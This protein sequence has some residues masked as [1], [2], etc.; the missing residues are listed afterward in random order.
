MPKWAEG[1]QLAV[2]NGTLVDSTVLTDSSNATYHEVIKSDEIHNAEICAIWNLG[3]SPPTVATVSTYIEFNEPVTRVL[4]YSSDGS[5]WT[6]ISMGM[7]PSP[8]GC[9]YTGETKN[10]T[11]GIA[12]QYWRFSM[13]AS[14]FGCIEQKAKMAEFRLL[15][16][17]DVLLTEDWG[18]GGGETPRRRG[19]QVT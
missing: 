12:A 4:E 2:D 16:D 3:S 10:P 6:S 8:L 9:T 14:I 18:G 15:D 5:S 1:Y 13:R 7:A 19:V 11:P 17:S